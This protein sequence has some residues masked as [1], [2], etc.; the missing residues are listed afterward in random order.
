MAPPSGRSNVSPNPTWLSL[1]KAAQHLDLS[2]AALRRRLERS[3]KLGKDGAVEARVSG[4]LARK[5]GD[6]WRVLFSP[7]WLIPS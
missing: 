1:P 4:V 5:F 7:E 2:P 3:A 6:R